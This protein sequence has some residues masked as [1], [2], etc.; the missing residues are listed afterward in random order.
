MNMA[1]AVESVA[2]PPA[3]VHAQISNRLG[4]GAELTVVVRK[5][6]LLR[7]ISGVGQEVGCR[8]RVERGLVLA[9]LD[10]ENRGVCCSI[11]IAGASRIVGDFC[12]IPTG[13]VVLGTPP[14]IAM[15]HITLLAMCLL[16]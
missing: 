11:P 15:K 12:R 1:K 4:V 2:P 8:L 6:A 14:R 16:R 5:R 3:P 7:R 9:P 10:G 13:N